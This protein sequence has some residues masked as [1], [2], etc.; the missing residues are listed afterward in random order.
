M[1]QLLRLFLS[2]SWKVIFASPAQETDH[3]VDLEAMGARKEHIQ[4]NDASFDVFVAALQPTIVLF[5]RFMMEEQFGWRVA[6][7]CPNAL[8][9]LDTE[10]LHCLRKTRQ[11]AFTSGK[12]FNIEDLFKSDIAKREIASIY[13]CDLSLIISEFEMQLLKEHFKISE[14]LLYYL[15]FMLKP[16]TINDSSKLLSFEQRKHFVTIGNFRHEPNWNAVL[17]LKETIWPL[18]KKQLP[19]AELHIYGAYP[20]PKAMQLNDPTEGFLIKGWASDAD[21][22]MQRS[23]ICLAPL[24]FGAGLKGKLVTAMKNGTPVVTTT[25]GAE[26]IYGDLPYNGEVEDDALIFANKAVALYQNET[27]WL[28]CQ[29]NGIQVLNQRFNGPELQACFIDRVKVP[30]ND[31]SAHRDANFIGSLLQHQTMQ[32]TKYMSKWIEAKN[33]LEK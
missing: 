21:D 8:R 33:K 20:P 17:Y 11:E 32:S 10:D 7:H 4:L 27:L 24:R 22:V 3:M 2:Q 25:I 16:M 28:Q 15:P 1:M 29:K 9:I 5:D 13:R 12:Q 18:I 30:L 31:L 19:K 23:R 26:G 6:A 14:S